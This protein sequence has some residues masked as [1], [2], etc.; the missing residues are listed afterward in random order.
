MQSS[1]RTTA[2]R[3]LGAHTKGCHPAVRRLK[4]YIV[5]KEHSSGNKVQAFSDSMW[6]ILRH[7]FVNVNIYIGA[8]LLQNQLFSLSH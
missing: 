8:K 4:I 7:I 6:S 1:F 3:Y 2:R 5:V